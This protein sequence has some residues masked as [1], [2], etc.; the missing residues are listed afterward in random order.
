[1]TVLTVRGIKVKRCFQD[2]NVAILKC[3]DTVFRRPYRHSSIAL[4]GILSLS[5]R[6]KI[7]ASDCLWI[8]VCQNVLLTKIGITMATI[9]K[10]IGN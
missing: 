7:F 4:K 6:Y 10:K 1:M 8:E 3:F 9:N 5:D 2:A